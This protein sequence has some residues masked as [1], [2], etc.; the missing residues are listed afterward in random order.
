M[1]FYP[2]NTMRAGTVFIYRQTEVHG[3]WHAYWMSQSEQVVESVCELLPCDSEAST[4]ATRVVIQTIWQAVGADRTWSLDWNNSQTGQGKKINK[5]IGYNPLCSMLL[6]R[7]ALWEHRGKNNQGCLVKG[8]WGGGDAPPRLVT[9]I[10][11]ESPV[12]ESGRGAST[13]ETA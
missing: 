6:Q 13:A 8:Q 3:G 12:L 9:P 10:A 11:T 1:S 2:H 4:L 7:L 5:Q